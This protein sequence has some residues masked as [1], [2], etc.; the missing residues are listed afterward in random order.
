MQSDLRHTGLNVLG[1]LA[2]GAH[3]CLFYQTKQ[4]LLD[5]LVPFFTAGVT[6]GEAGVWLVSDPLTPPDA[7]AALRRSRP[8]LDRQLDRGAIE[9]LSGPA[10]YL[11]GGKFKWERLLHEWDEK[12]RRATERGFDGLRAT[13]NLL[14]SPP[15]QTFQEYEQELQ[16]FLLGRNMIVLCTYSL[17]TSSAADVFDVA[18]AHDITVARRNGAWRFVESAEVRDR[19]K[20]LSPREREVLGWVAKG[21]TAAQIAA[22][23]NIKKRT[24]D[25]HTSTAMRKLAAA[26]RTQAVAVA[27]RA[28]I[29]DF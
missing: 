28:R 16:R 7:E 8:D 11:D 23:L 14:S 12:H 27:L 26:N 15:Y 24:V 19:A 6:N 17:L 3:V 18:G 13:G 5:V 4:D 1:D 21:K 25:E 10:W 22:I 29:I 20:R 9:F 2:W